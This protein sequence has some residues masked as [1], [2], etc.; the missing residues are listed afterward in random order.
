MQI[1]SY[2]LLMVRFGPYDVDFT[3][4]EVRKSGVRVRVQEQQLRVLQ[5][6]VERPGELITRD[7]LR[8][9]LWPGDTFVDFDR[10]LNVAVAKLRQSLNDSADRPLYIETIARKGYRF[11]APV[12][13]SEAER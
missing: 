1:I 13:K 2:Y 5:A 12:V 4:A 8:H 11:I 3:L 6:L 10:S 9:C 7:E